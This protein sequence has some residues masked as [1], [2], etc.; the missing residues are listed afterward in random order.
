MTLAEIRRALS[1]TPRLG[2]S[3]MVGLYADQLGVQVIDV[4][5]S[6]ADPTDFVGKPMEDSDA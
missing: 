6:Q 1:G 2:K 4:R 3:A 5:L